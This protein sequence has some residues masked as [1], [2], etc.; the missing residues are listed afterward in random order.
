[1]KYYVSIPIKGEF[2]VR[3]YTAVDDRGIARE[4]KR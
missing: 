3:E 1:V 4:T 2:R